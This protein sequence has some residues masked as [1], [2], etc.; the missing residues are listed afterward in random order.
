MRTEPSG[1]RT[2]EVCASRLVLGRLCGLQALAQRG[3]RHLH[4]LVLLQVLR[5]PALEGSGGRELQD[6]QR[7]QSRPRLFGDGM[8]LLQDAVEALGRLRRQAVSRGAAEGRLRDGMLGQL[9]LSRKALPTSLNV[10]V[11]WCVGPCTLTG[12]SAGT[13]AKWGRLV[14]RLAVA[15]CCRC[16]SPATALMQ[17]SL[18]A[19]RD[20]QVRS[21]K[22][23][24]QVISPA[25]SLATNRCREQGS[26]ASRDTA[27]AENELC[28]CKSPGACGFSPPCFSCAARPCTLCADRL[29]WRTA[30]LSP[31]AALRKR[32]RTSTA[33]LCALRLS[34][35]IT[36]SLWCSE[37][38]VEEC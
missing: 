25:E 13:G 17:P 9:A 3:Q 7:G 29:G 19:C 23:V 10:L 20:A 33:R 2:E 24:A 28:I 16:C 31:S 30:V 14:S 12:T 26:S 27:G 38:C 21:Q 37:G 22:R 32:A 6:A 11:S 18:S 5:Q 34:L 15:S 4:R 35:R 8:E 1:R 36:A